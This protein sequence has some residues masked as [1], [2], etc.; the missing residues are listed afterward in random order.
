MEVVRKYVDASSLMTIMKLPDNFKNQKLEVIILPTEEKES[1]EKKENV[2]DIVQSLVG[3]IPYT[4]KTLSE[5][6]D[7]RLRKYEITDWY[8]YFVRCPFE[9]RTI[10]LQGGRS[11]GI[12]PVW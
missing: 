5:L 4:N 8:E 11:T 3:A 7:E 10:L 1:V 9:K 12:G 2:K 6:R